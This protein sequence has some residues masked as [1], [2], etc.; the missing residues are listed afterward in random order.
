MLHV[1]DEAPDAGVRSRPAVKHG[2]GTRCVPKPAGQVHDH[3]RLGIGITDEIVAGATVEGFALVEPE[4]KAAN[5]VAKVIVCRLVISRLQ[6]RR[7]SPFSH[8][9]IVAAF[10]LD[11]ITADTAIQGIVL[12]VTDQ[13]V[14]EPASDYR[15]EASQGVRAGAAGDLRYGAQI[16]G[17]SSVR[18][19]I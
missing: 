18:V 16:D 11:K 4:I 10:S 7:I 15:L 19:L 3:A 1:V 17:D 14:V 8:Q 13:G 6:R 5:L 9:G 2:N 12:R